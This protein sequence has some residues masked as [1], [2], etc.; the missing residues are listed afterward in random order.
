MTSK[1]K[2]GAKKNKR[3]WKASSLVPTL[4]CCPLELGSSTKKPVSFPFICAYPEKLYLGE[5]AK[6]WVRKR[7]LKIEKTQGDIL[8]R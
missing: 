8:K 1:K 2:I 7:I 5:R 6:L 4:A 3:I